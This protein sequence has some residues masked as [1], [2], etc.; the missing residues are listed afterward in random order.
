MQLKSNKRKKRK[1]KL[2]RR[3]VLIKE[4]RMVDRIMMVKEIS[5]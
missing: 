2:S 4:V 3:L 1:K 5:K